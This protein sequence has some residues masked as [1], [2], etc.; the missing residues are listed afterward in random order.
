LRRVKIDIEELI[1]ILEQ[2][3]DTGGT[4]QVILFDHEGTAAL[5][6]ADEPDNIIAFA[7]DD[8]D[9]DALH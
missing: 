4:Q 8:A 1:S 2:M 7:P 6:D 3:R 5:C 9:E